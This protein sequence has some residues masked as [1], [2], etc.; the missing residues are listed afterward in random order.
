MTYAVTF[1][2]AA[3]D[4][5]IRLNPRTGQW[6]EPESPALEMVINTLRTPKGSCLAVPDLGVEWS[7]IDTLR[8]DAAATAR[9]VILAGLGSLLSDGWIESVSVTVEVDP[10]RG[11]L[12]Y[13]VSFVDP[14]LKKKLT[15][16]GTI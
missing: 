14:R 5:D 10:S 1:A 9:A 12:L 3:S 7:R 8:T 16:T 4:G 11:R 15:A 13:S 2:H 6:V